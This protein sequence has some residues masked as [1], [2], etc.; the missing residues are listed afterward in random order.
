M[1]ESEAGRASG[2]CTQWENSLIPP[3]SNFL[4]ARAF[5]DSPNNYY[6]RAAT[7]S[8][9]SQKLRQLNALRGKKRTELK[10]EQAAFLQDALSMPT[11]A[12]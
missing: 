3:A 5:Q 11:P 1:A 4:S 7:V 10:G 8:A 12:A 2:K 9:V 6:P